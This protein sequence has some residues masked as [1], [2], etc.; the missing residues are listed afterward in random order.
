VKKSATRKTFE[1]NRL[2]LFEDISAKLVERGFVVLACRVTDPAASGGYERAVITLHRNA[3]DATDVCFSAG[4]W[5]K[6]LGRIRSEETAH[7]EFRCGDVSPA[8]T[9]KPYSGPTQVVPIRAAAV[10]AVLEKAYGQAQIRKAA[11]KEQEET[12]KTRRSVAERVNAFANRHRVCHVRDGDAVPHLRFKPGLDEATMIA[13]V[14][15]LC[16]ARHGGVSLFSVLAVE[17]E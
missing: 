3:E 17:S 11:R 6:P 16:A 2:Q 8:R 1:A 15:A 4:Q 12:R 14:D 13:I 9:I 5:Y 10:A 7:V